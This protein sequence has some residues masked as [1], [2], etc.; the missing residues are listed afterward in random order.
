MPTDLEKQTV[1]FTESGE[2]AIRR[3]VH[4]V[5]SRLRSNAIDEAVRRRGFPVEVTSSDVERASRHFGAQFASRV[6]GS[7]TIDALSAEY[8]L[9]DRMMLQRYREMRRHKTSVL[10]RVGSLY[11]RV[12]I[13]LAVSGVV[14]P[15]LYMLYRWLSHDFAWRI[16]L[17][18]AA[19]GLLTAGMGFVLR[20]VASR[21]HVMEFRNHADRP[22]YKKAE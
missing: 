22:V 13:S 4:G 14:V 2:A 18:T 21:S 6:G 10:D 7:G 17:L 19:A 9:R 15:A 16:G 11:T 12:G 5:E 8:M 3:T 20:E 1:T